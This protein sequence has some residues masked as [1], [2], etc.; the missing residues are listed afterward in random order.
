MLNLFDFF[1][2]KPSEDE[3]LISAFFHG[4][5]DAEKEII[6]IFT[7]AN[8]RSALETILDKHV[9]DFSEKL[10]SKNNDDKDH[11]LLDA[12]ATKHIKDEGIKHI[13]QQVVDNNPLTEETL[14]DDIIDFYQD[15]LNFLIT[16][17]LDEEVSNETEATDELLNALEENIQE[18]ENEMK[19]KIDEISG[20]SIKHISSQIQANAI[21]HILEEKEE[22]EEDE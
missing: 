21:R 7:T 3:V 22:E 17:L 2:K 18:I 5:E 4:N 11:E 6:E 13:W 14:K 15:E 10:N 12:I 8:I 9:S 16:T 1:K 20:I 19:E